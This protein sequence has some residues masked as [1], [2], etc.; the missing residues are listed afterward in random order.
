MAT[1]EKPGLSRALRKHQPQVSR[2]GNDDG[3]DSTSND[4]E[5]VPLKQQA[6]Q[7]RPG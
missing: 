4:D 6:L 7:C 1:N 5:D 3:G 2:R